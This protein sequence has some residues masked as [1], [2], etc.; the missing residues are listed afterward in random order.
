[1]DYTGPTPSEVTFRAGLSAGDQ[2]CI[3]V[4]VID[5]DFIEDEETF[6]IVLTV[7]PGDEPSVVFNGADVTTF[8]II[9]DPNDSKLHAVLLMAS[10][11]STYLVSKLSVM[12]ITNLKLSFSDQGKDGITFMYNTDDLYQSAQVCTRPIGN[13]NHYII[14]DVATSLKH[15]IIKIR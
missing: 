1:M 8:T 11:A 13:S 14:S 7:S 9:Q 5:D 12:L 15:F 2:R 6:D 4:T 10:P 3:V